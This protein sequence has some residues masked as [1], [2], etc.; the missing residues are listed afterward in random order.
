MPLVAMSEFMICVRRL[1]VCRAVLSSEG[2]ALVEAGF[3]L[4]DKA[5]VLKM[6]GA[7]KLC[8][9]EQILRQMNFL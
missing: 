8:C 3:L 5:E 9:S 6:M 2:Y 4:S 7:L 1:F